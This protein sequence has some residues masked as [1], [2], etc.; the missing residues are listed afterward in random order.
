MLLET[1]L[2][3]IFFGIGALMI[4]ILGVELDSPSID[5]DWIILLGMI[6]PVVAFGIACAFVQLF[7][8]IIKDKRK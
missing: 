2:T 8:K 1:I 4:R 3:L 6:A 5:F 7:K